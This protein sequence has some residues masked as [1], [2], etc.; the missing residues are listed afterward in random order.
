MSSI[1]RNPRDSRATC[2]WSNKLRPRPYI[3]RSAASSGASM[4]SSVTKWRHSTDGM[5]RKASSGRPLIRRKPMCSAQAELQSVTAARLD[6]FALGRA[7]GK[8]RLQLEGAHLARRLAHAQVGRLPALHRA[9]PSV[10][11]SRYALKKR[12]AMSAKSMTYY[13]IPNVLTGFAYRH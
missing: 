3:T 8:D 7:K 9:P 4:P 2:R 11:R 5:T 12:T 1:H 13:L 6:Q 10:G